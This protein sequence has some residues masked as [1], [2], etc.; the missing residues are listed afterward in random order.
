MLICLGFYFI[1]KVNFQ[2]DFLKNINDSLSNQNQS[3]LCPSGYNNVH[4][5]Y[6]RMYIV[7]VYKINKKL[8]FWLLKVLVGFCSFFLFFF[9]FKQR[10]KSY[11]AGSG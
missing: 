11:V 9:L 6:T 10:D 4:I 2:V 5:L 8:S 1:Y 3:H 7:R